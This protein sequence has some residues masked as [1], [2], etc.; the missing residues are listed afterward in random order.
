MAGKRFPIAHL[1]EY[2]DDALTVEAKMKDRSKA[3]EAAS[4]L[5]AMLQQR[6]DKR[7]AM[8]QYLADKNGVS[9]QEMWNS[10]LDKNAEIS[11]EDKAEMEKQDQS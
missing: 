2:Y 6:A 8:V 11:D 5:C 7:N 10:L 9:F 3:A 4:L 1:G